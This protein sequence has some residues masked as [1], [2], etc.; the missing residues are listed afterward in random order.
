MGLSPDTPI[1][2]W[3]KD[4]FIE[5]HFVPYK[6]LYETWVDPTQ[7][8]PVVTTRLK[9]AQQAIVPL[10]RELYAILKSSPLVNDG[11]LEAMRL[12]KRAVY[13]HRKAPVADKAPSFYTNVLD[14]HRIRIF[15]Y[16]SQARK[17]GKPAGQHG[18]EIRW[19]FSEELVRDAE[20]LPNSVFDTASPYTL[21][22]SPKD[23]GRTVY[24]ALRWEN[25]RGLKGPWSPLEITHVP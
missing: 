17:S 21:S 16:P 4:V 20:N 11:D 6:G 18:V 8:T 25:T 24:I 3:Y 14:S 23:Y 9:N 19:G 2:K 7:Q 22:F 12:P 10:Y 1:G 5:R 15:Y 13:E